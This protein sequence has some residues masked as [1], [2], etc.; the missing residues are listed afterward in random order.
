MNAPI[1]FVLMQKLPDGTVWISVP[2]EAREIHHVRQS[3]IAGFLAKQPRWAVS[4]DGAFL[5]GLD[6][7][8][9]EVKAAP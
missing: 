9:R 3:V 7:K 1:R 2:Q 5:Y 6:E 4:L 8:G